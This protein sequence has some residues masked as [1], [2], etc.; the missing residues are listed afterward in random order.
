M[1]QVIRRHTPVGLLPLLVL[2]IAILSACFYASAELLYP[3]SAWYYLFL[4][5]GVTMVAI[6]IATI[7]SA[8][9]FFDLYAEVRVTTRVVLLQ[10][11]CQALGTAILM[12][13][14]AIY[15]F[16]DWT[17]PHLLMLYSSGFA[18]LVLFFWRI[19]FSLLIERI[20]GFDKLL[21]VGRNS[22]AEA[23]AH[24]VDTNSKT[25][26]R[27]IGFVDDDPAGARVL[28]NISSLRSVV[29]QYKPG[30]LVVG[31]SERRDTMPVADLVALR[32]SGLQIEDAGKTFESVCQRVRL[33][34]LSEEQVM[35]TRAF[36]PSAGALRLARVFSFLLAAVC[37]P[38]LFPLFLLIA[39][40]LK[41]RSK[42]PVLLR[43]PRAGKD[44]R[45]FFMLRFRA[46]SALRRFHLDAMPELFNV[47]KGD[48][49]WVGPRAEAPQGAR[50]M[51]NSLPFYEYRASVPPG[52]TGWAQIHQT[53]ENEA[54][55]QLALEYDLYYI[56]HMSLALNLYILV[57]SLKN[58]V[59][60]A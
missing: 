40:W 27:V 25:G 51:A 46:D 12:Q 32:F 41:L 45:N 3:P 38:L 48:M 5:G 13:T 47:L 37:L 21:F 15:L 52:I 50:E 31:L 56:K 20:G 4:D 22:T 18:L 28:G 7:I 42:Q 29:E 2:D 30:L 24:A 49:S 9:Y 58:R 54:D 34:E 35:F 55:C 33:A 23:V 10:Q 59:L 26:F 16:R 43:L 60:R 36:A 39:A 53:R 1:I 17:V 19:A 14:V 11:I 44:N 57:H 6:A 8:M